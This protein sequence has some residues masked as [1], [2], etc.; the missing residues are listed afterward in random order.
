[1]GEIR[2]GFDTSSK[3]GNED[4]EFKPFLRQIYWS[5]DK[6]SK[7]LLFLNSVT[8]QLPRFD[9]ITFIP[10]DNHFESVIARTDPFIGR[11]SDKMVD[12]WDGNI[13]VQNIAIAV[14][15]EP[16]M[17]DNKGRER[18]GSFQVKTSEYERRI[19]DDEGNV[20]E[21]TEVVVTPEVGFVQQSHHNFWNIVDDANSSDGE[22]H[23]NACQITRIGKGSDT[24]YKCKVYEDIPVDLSGLVEYIDGVSY[25]SEDIDDLVEQIGS[26]SNEDA[27]LKIGDVLIDKYIHE[28]ADEDR[29]EDLYQGITESL[30][31]FG[32]KKDKKEPRKT[33]RARPSE[34][35]PSVSRESPQKARLAE[36]RRQA[37]AKKS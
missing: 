29:Y 11:K 37:A 9:M 36:L 26:L 20:T 14:E 5:D 22:V 32:R 35:K 28:L 18:P 23:V 12:D 2:R 8:D 6:E 34:D 4:R 25:L 10:K 31:R 7:Y 24:V 13:S 15:L 19:L 3:S 17:E 27:A 21:D 33:S 30:D 1:M 16:V